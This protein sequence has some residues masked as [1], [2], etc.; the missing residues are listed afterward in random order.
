MIRSCARVL[1]LA[2]ALWHPSTQGQVPALPVPY[3]PSVGQ[4][5]KDV[6]WVPTSAS[7][8]TRMLDMANVTDR[9][10]VIDLGSGDGRTVIAAARRGAKALG[11]EYN[12]ELVALSKRSAELAGVTARAEFVKADIFA[13]DFSKATVITMF[14]LPDLN[15]KLRPTILGLEPGTRVVSNT[16]GMG[17]WEPDARTV[18][19]P[20]A[21][22]ENEWCTALLWIV[23]A[24]VGGTTATAQGILVLEQKFQFLTGTLSREGTSIRVQGK[25]TGHEVALSAGSHTLQGTVVRGR[26][27]LR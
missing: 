27:E 6:P 26:L 22:C 13:F 16:F 2:L 11:I 17:D 12:A 14:L 10:Y 7:V 24:K 15:M 9:D 25:V 8:A 3:E 21:G 23:P 19:H 5:G 18:I 20:S 1:C 4:P